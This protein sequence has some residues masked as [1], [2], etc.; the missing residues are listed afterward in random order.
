MYVFF[1]LSRLFLLQGELPDHDADLMFLE[2]AE[3]WV[4]ISQTTMKFYE[5]LNQNQGKFLSQSHA[6]E[7]PYIP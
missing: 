2:R 7:K 5:S 3:D 4:E 1:T 6:Q